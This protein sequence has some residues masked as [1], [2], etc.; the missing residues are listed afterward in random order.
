MLPCTFPAK[1]IVAPNSPM[2]R[3]KASTQPA[4][5]PPAASGSATRAN[6][7]AGPA[8]SVRAASVSVR[9]DALEGGD[10]LAEVERRGDERD[11]EDD[12][13]LGER[14]H[15]AG[16]AQL[17]AEQAARAERRQQAMPATAGGSTSGSSISV[18][19][20]ARPRKRAR[21]EEVGGGR[22]EAE[23][24]RVGDEVRAHRHLERLAHRPGRAAAAGRRRSGTSRE[25]RDQRDRQ[26]RERR[27]RSQSARSAVN[28][29]ARM[30]LPRGGSPKPACLRIPRPRCERTLCDE[31]AARRAVSAPARRTAQNS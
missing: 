26:E 25:E 20:S 1:M 18:I 16:A 23:D 21:G 8:P 19:T 17:V 14:Q 9:V 15:D 22:A 12:R 31:C 6:I 7:R 10:R 28:Q 5:R 2:P 30:R 11:R 24:Q 13:P 27:R 4:A 29:A 3:A